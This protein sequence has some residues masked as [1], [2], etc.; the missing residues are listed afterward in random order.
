M[1]I[2]IDYVREFSNVPTSV[3]EIVGYS[4]HMSLSG[5][6]GLVLNLS[7]SFLA[8]ANDV[9]RRITRV[10]DRTN[11]T[12]LSFFFSIRQTICFHEVFR[13]AYRAYN[14]PHVCVSRSA[15]FLLDVK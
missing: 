14:V 7:V 9:S 13:I 3:I 10:G 4:I 2:G 11:A 6:S 1:I 5:Y 15:S 12:Y 8:V